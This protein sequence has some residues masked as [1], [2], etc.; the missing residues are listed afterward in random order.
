MNDMQE[1][2][3]ISSP[4]KTKQNMHESELMPKALIIGFDD[5]PKFDGNDPF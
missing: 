3:R 5:D 4:H 2:K 1:I